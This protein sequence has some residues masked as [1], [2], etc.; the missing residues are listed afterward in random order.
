M[1]TVICLSGILAFWTSSVFGAM[2]KHLVDASY[3]GA[4]AVYSADVDGDGDQ[5]VLGASHNGNNISWSENSNGDGSVWVEHLIDGSFSLAYS[6]YSADV[7][8]DGDQDVLGASIG[9]SEI[10]WWENTVGNGTSWAKHTVDGSFSGAACVQ[11][12]DV[13]GDG[14]QD[15]LGAASGGSEIAWW[16]NTAGNGTAWTRRTVDASFSAANWVSASDVDGDGDQ[17]ILGAAWSGDEIAWWEN[18]AGSGVSWTKH[19]VDGSFDGAACVPTVN[20]V[21]GCILRIF[22]PPQ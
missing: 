3:S 6:V 1:K 19:T 7:D 9:A 18:T 20:S 12:A 14:D 10:A 4:F 22:S 21:R 16:E 13:D 17:D 2:P 11:T 15:V 8:G 5:D